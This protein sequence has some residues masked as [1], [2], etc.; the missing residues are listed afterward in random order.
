MIVS[1]TSSL[2]GCFKTKF[3]I[4]IIKIENDVTIKAK[5]STTKNAVATH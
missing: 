4:G 2:D 5:A 3:K 1:H